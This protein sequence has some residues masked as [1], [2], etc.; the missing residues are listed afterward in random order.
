MSRFN[1]AYLELKDST[2]TAVFEFNIGYRSSGEVD[3][4]FLMG[5]RGQYVT[6]VYNQLDIPGDV[7]DIAAN[8]RAAF[9]IDGGAGEWTQQLE[10]STALEDVQ[11]GDGSGD[12]TE[13][14]TTGPTNV[15]PRDASGSDIKAQTRKDILE[16]WVARSRTDSQ[17]PAFLFTGEWATAK[18]H[19]EA[20]A[21]NQAMPVSVTNLTT[22]LPDPNDGDQVSLTGTIQVR[23]L[24]TFK[25][26]TPPAVLE[27]SNIGTYSEDAAAALEDMKDE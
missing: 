8:R 7:D 26:L 16:L 25:D 14:G 12:P 3:K 6:E 17:Q 22:D 23:M 13:P 19:S 1:T 9:Q 2:S 5:P 10:F 27:D 18:H 24:S 4:N 11:W 21:F 20:G 15:T